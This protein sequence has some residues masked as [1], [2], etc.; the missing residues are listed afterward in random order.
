VDLFTPSFDITKDGDAFSKL[1]DDVNYTFTLSNNS[2]ENT[3]PLTCTATDSL[4]GVVFGPA[5]L[6]QGDPTVVNRTRTVQAG[7]DDPLVN[8]VTLSCSLPEGFTNVLGD[9]SD[10]HTVDLLHPGYTMIKE[11]ANEPVPQDGPALWMVTFTNTGDVTLTITADDGIGTFDLP[12]ANGWGSSL[13][14]DVSLPGPF[15]GQA[16]VSNTVN[17]TAVVHSDFGTFTNVIA[18]QSATS[19]CYVAGDAKVIKLTNGLPND[20]TNPNAAPWNFTLQDCAGDGCDK[21]DP[22]IGQVTSPPSMVEFDLDLVPVELDPNQYYRLCEV[23]IPAA[24]TNTWEGD[25]DDDGTPE[26]FIPFVPAVND[27]PVVIPPG[28]GGVFDPMYAP[29]PAQWTNDERCVNFAVNAGAT[30]VFRINNDFPGGEPRTIGYWKNWDSCS[31]G[32]QVD[33]AIEYGGETPQERIGNGRALLDDVLQPPGITVGLL[34]MVADA[35]VF[36]CDEGT[37]NAVHI[38]DKR[39]IDGNH[40]KKARDAA[41]GL[42]AQ[43]LAAIAN[44]TAGALV[45]PEAGQAV[46]DAQTLL[47]AI[48]FDGTGDYFKKNV[49]EINGQT[50]QAANELAGILDSYNNGILCAP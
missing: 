23:L 9:A 37:Q 4:L 13:M 21:D 16:T 28:W 48:G 43:L 46:I 15:T 22:I 33:T 8:T 24:W 39:A 19:E 49:D 1:G 50:K 11:C 5:V 20:E 17:A 32:N 7:D 41:Y 35:D 27:D 10:D 6:P 12:P 47:V 38:L 31:G 36:D 30:E 45:C 25:A 26:S 29:P 44:D 2:S 42:A 3:P 18:P 14:F 34:N 40:K